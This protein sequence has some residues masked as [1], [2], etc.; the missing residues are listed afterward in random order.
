MRIGIIG[1]GHIGGTLARHLRRAGHQL[2][3]ASSSPAS[4]RGL[5]D[6]LDVAAGDPAAAG[7]T[8]AVIL[9]VPGATLPALLDGLAPGLA[10]RTVIDATNPYGVD[11]DVPQ[12][13]WLRDRLPEAQVVRAFNTLYWETLRDKAFSDPRLALVLS[14]GAPAAKRTTA[15]LI[16][17]IGFAPVDLGGM[18]GV[19]RQEPD[20][21]LYTVEATEADLRAR[22]PS[23][24]ARSAS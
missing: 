15:G 13:V 7:D 17:D 24:G 8:E 9:A 12:G 3:L 22:I 18:D 2:T 21:P 10:G 4:A 1:V 23:T 5:A 16:T 19:W 14:G 20:G 11:R 6:E